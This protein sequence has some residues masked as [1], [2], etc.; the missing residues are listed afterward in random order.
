MNT[1]IPPHKKGN[2]PPIKTLSSH[3]IFVVGSSI[4]SFRKI[5]TT[6]FA[7]AFVLGFILPELLYRGKFL[8]PSNIFQPL[9]FFNQERMVKDNNT[10]L[11]LNNHQGHC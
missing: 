8:Y 9:V 4:F 10:K 3:N 7:K 2:M 6:N 11:T 5:N 1:H